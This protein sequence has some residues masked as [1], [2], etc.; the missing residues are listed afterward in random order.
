MMALSMKSCLYS[1]GSNLN[2]TIRGSKPRGVCGFCPS[3]GSSQSKDAE[4]RAFPVLSVDFMGKPLHI[5]DQKGKRDWSP[6]SSGNFFIHAQTSICVSRAMRWWDKTL[7]PNMVEIQSAQELVDSLLNAGDRLV[8]VDFYSPGCGGCKALHPKICQLAESNP[9][10]IF[11]KVNY[12][13]LKTMCH[14]LH[15][16][17]L[18]FFRFY[19]GAEGRLCSF[20]CTNATIKK[21]RDALAKHGTERCSLGPA[22][23]LN[24]AELMNLASIGEISKYPAPLRSTKEASVED[25]IMGSID[26]SGVLRETG[27]K[28]ELRKEMLC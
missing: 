8:I 6:K 15:I 10:T 26:L 21:F 20:S 17:V 25:M 1:Y 19:R 27:N 22:K 28:M 4:S 11:I 14:G 16:H 9:N 3:F 12:E 18:P 24:E 7:K 2:E 5:S 13:N 23:G